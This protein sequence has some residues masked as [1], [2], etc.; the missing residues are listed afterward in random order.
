MAIPAQK[1]LLLPLFFLSGFSALV[2]EVIWARMLSLVFGSTVEAV[3]AVVAAFMAGLAVG[4]YF[5]GKWADKRDDPLFIYS[6]TELGIGILSLSLY[7][8]IMLLPEIDSTFHGAFSFKNS[9][10][11]PHAVDY[12]IEFLMVFIPASLMGAT[13][14]L[15]V[16]SYVTS[17]NFVGEGISIIYT[18]NT[19]GAVFGAFFT[20]FFLIPFFGIRLTVFTAVAINM[21]LALTSYLIGR[22]HPYWSERAAVSP[23]PARHQLTHSP[24]LLPNPAYKAPAPVT[25][26]SVLIVLALSGFASLAYQMAWTRVI[27]MVIGNSVYAFSTILTA[28]LMGIAIGSFAFIKQIDKTKDKV[29]LLAILQLS[30]FFLVVTFLPRADSLPVLFLTLFR[31]LPSNFAGIIII[32]FIVTFSVV[33]IPTIL[34]GAT[35]PVAARIYINM[36][37]NIGEGLGRLYSVNT[38]GAI[39]GSFLAGFVL[40]PELGV[41]KTIL[42]I[43]TLNLLS[44][45]ILIV[46]AER[47]QKVWRFTVPAMSVIF[48]SYNV[49]TIQDWN[50]NVLNRGVYIYAEWL[51]KI[52]N[53]GGSLEEFSKEFKLLYYEEGREGTVAVSR[54]RD[55]V[56]SLQINGKTDASTTDADMQTQIM[57]A[58]LPLLMHP[59]PEEIAIVGLGSGVTLGAAGRFPVKKI[60]CIEIIPEVVKANRYFTNF[61]HN[62]LND[63]RVSLIV[64]D[65]RRHLTVSKK[66]YDI[67]IDEPSNPW[68]AGSSNLFTLEFFRLVKDR[69][70]ENGILCQWFNLYTIDTSE[71]KILLN[72][73]RTVFP[74]VTVWAFSEEDLIILGSNNPLQ[75]DEDRLNY[76]FSEFEIKK[77][78]LRAGIASKDQINSAYLIGNS[79]LERFCEGAGLN[80][81]NRPTIEFEAPKTFYRPTAGKNVS[82]ILSSAAIMK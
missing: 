42:F 71:L 65:A 59:D 3:S 34:M 28:F 63:P 19:L 36:A 80:T 24:S 73:F 77:E 52:D 20:G 72:T 30:L 67:I 17:R 2:Y 58:A 38:V 78:L 37:D 39:F 70:K 29:L 8:V 14:P 57:I 81:D 12:I 79:E 50:S 54:T 64:G 49:G 82:A 66:K 1:K 47:L 41:Q 33:L 9:F 13:F 68:I 7:F 40:I 45:V 16:K 4:S 5:M 46:Q 23:T 25:A 27:A 55:R 15:M 43:S 48:F 62:A 74:H 31:N 56:L 44:G 22:F 21:V 26:A 69:L 51:K 6:L 53:M 11:P 18:V 61:N 60:E 75:I 32:E 76:A 35:F 10:F